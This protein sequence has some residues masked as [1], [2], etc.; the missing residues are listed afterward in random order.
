MSV[1]KPASR[2]APGAAQCPLSALQRLL[3]VT[4]RPPDAPGHPEIS[5]LLPNLQSHHDVLVPLP[6]P[7]AGSSRV[8]Q[9]SHWSHCCRWRPRHHGAVD[10]IAVLLLLLL[11]SLLPGHPV[12]NVLTRYKAWLAQCIHPLRGKQL[13]V[14]KCSCGL[15]YG[16]VSTSRMAQ[17]LM[18]VKAWMFP[19]AGN[20]AMCHKH[21]C[22]QDQDTQQQSGMARSSASWVHQTPSH[23]LCQLGPTHSSDLASY[24]SAVAGRTLD[25]RQDV[26][27][28]GEGV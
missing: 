6:L 28:C 14:S 16:G 20:V 7:L 11:P 27:A 12:G 4:L 18:A 5:R 26:S 10:T 21:N 8:V 1:H 23:H 25:I 22:R 17:G 3:A 24:M 2:H 19:P 13:A 15:P 9:P